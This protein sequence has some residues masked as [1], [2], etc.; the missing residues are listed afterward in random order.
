MSLEFNF[1]VDRVTKGKIYPALAR[2]QGRPYT[3]SWREF[4]QHYPY[5]T[6]L[7][8]QEYCD[9]HGALIN[10][11]YINDRLPANTFY[12]VCL[13][14]F[15][16]DIDYFELMD[17]DVCRGLRQGDLRVLFYYHEGDNPRRIKNRLDTLAKNHLMPTNCYVFVS[18]NTQADQLDNFVTF[19]DFELWYYQRN[20][21]KAAE[22][23]HTNPREREFVCLSRLHKWWRATALADLQR[24]NTLDNSYWSYCEAPED[25]EY[26]QDNPIELD[27]I[28]RLRWDLEKFVAS[29]PYVSDELDQD[30]RNDHSHH[31]PKYHAN[32]YCHIVLESQ[33]DVD[34]SGGAF[35]TEKTFKPIKHGQLFFVA[36]GA[37]SLQA[38]RDLGYCTFDSVLDNSYDLE[39]NHTQRWIK[40]HEAIKKVQ[41]QGLHSLYLHCLDDIKYN[42]QLFLATKLDRLNT[43]HRK[44]NEQS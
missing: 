4:G 32:A 24:G 13:G 26:T 10:M 28:S 14:F 3:P 22:E 11:F 40:L 33:F 36:G 43:L 6:P 17:S 20:S 35:I 38:L 19:C 42:Q 37:G 15:D 23:A 44:I 9:A 30:Q 2:H 39:T 25:K 5:T 34:Q 41:A 7:R 8:L 1:V 27:M 12:P 21:N 18:S 16:F 31:V 29:A